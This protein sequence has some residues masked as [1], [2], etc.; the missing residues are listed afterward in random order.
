MGVMQAQTTPYCT[1]FWGR[2]KGIAR[3][4][5]GN[6]ERINTVNRA[7]WIY[8]LMFRPAKNNCES[9]LICL[10][11]AATISNPRVKSGHLEIM[12]PLTVHQENFLT[13]Q[14]STRISFPR[15]FSNALLTSS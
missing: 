7:I 9:N 1:H 3:V 14:M 13:D 4:N 2:V 8:S 5:S 10:L 11:P 12:V 15:N 6:H